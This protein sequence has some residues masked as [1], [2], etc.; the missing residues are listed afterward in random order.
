MKRTV[1]LKAI[2]KAFEELGGSG[3]LKDL[4]S[5]IECNGSLPL[6]KYTD[7]KS[8]VRKTIYLHSSDCEI[9]KGIPNDKND[10][11]RTVEGKGNGRWEVRN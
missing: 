11:F 2:L 3:T 1:W 8:Q 7:W 4:Y 9:F 5:M 6:N 10:I